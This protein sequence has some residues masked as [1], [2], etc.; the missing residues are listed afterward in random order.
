[1]KKY[2]IKNYNL[3]LFLSATHMILT[4][5][6]PIVIIIVCDLFFEKEQAQETARHLINMIYNFT[7]SEFLSSVLI[8][9]IGMGPFFAITT[10]NHYVVC[11]RIDAGRK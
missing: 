7:G 5:L 8:T 1:M 10:I 2:Y 11:K 3:Y 9:L 6:F 4:M